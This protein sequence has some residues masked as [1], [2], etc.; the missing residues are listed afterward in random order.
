MNKYLADIQ[1]SPNGGFRGQGP[2]GLE[3]KSSVESLS[4]FNGF[5]SA[6]IGVMTIIGA[7]WFIFLF[8]TGAIGIISSSGD[9][10]KLTEARSKITTGLIGLVV[11]IA[12][13]FIIDL[14]GKLI[15]LDI[16][17]SI[18]QVPFLSIF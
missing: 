2:L 10:Q 9:K 8:L 17:N 6:A 18:M 13:V 1:L 15:G 14:V 3:G 4:I 5:L 16:L 11:M 12:S 7:I